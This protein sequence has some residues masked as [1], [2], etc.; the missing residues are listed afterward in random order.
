MLTLILSAILAVG[1]FYLFDK[2]AYKRDNLAGLC[3][4]VA[5]VSVIVFCV[6]GIFALVVAVEKETEYQNKLYEKEVIEY[7]V[8]HITEDIVGNEL[9]F[10]DIVKFNNHLR[11]AKKWVNN[12]WTN[13]FWNEDVASIDYIA[14]PWF[15]SER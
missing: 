11:S 4:A 10:N 6:F 8:E 7:R 13:I 9:L 12:P 14:L 2:F 15:E 3:A 5:T 1:G